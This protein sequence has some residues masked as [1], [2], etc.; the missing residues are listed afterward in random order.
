MQKTDPVGAY[1][2][3]LAAR[4]ST[5]GGGAVSA[6]SG[7]Q[8]CALIAMVCRFT[9]GDELREV[10]TRAEAIREACLQFASDDVDCF[11]AVMAV[12]REGGEPLQQALKSAAEVPLALIESLLPL[13]EDIDQL[14]QKGNQNL[15]TD[16]GIAAQQI[17]AAIDAAQLNVLVN[18]K[19]VEDPAWRQE[20]LA[21]LKQADQPRERLIE[22]KDRALSDL[23]P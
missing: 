12:W 7:A 11:N 5:P 14:A 19:S 16:T 6:V 17:I 1:L 3:A 21:R 22:I 18:L 23:Q 15:I 13:A 10:L 9:K 20:T 8:A 4:T 2:D